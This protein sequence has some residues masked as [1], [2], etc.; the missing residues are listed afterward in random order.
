VNLIVNNTHSAPAPVRYLSGPQTA[1]MIAASVATVYRIEKT[2][3]TFP[4]RVRISPRRVAWRES[5]V[6]E[7]LRQ[8]QCE[9]EAQGHPAGTAAAQR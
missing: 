1:Q 3:P 8:R 7:W 5:A 4:R 9:A 2:D 6:M